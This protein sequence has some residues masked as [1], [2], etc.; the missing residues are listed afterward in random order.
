MQ[1]DY[2]TFSCRCRLRL[3]NNHKDQS[4]KSTFLLVIWF[5]T[6]LL[7]HS[8]LVKLCLFH[9]KFVKPCHSLRNLWFRVI[10]IF[11]FYYRI[12]FLTLAL[13]TCHACLV[14]QK[15]TSQELHTDGIFFVVRCV[16]LMV[17]WAIPTQPCA[18]VSVFNSYIKVIWMGWGY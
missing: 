2:T 14:A 5:A 8:P 11:N 4:K 1:R 9:T 18:V 7:H 15:A 17:V 13:C 10:V 6:L 3:E 12:V 16:F